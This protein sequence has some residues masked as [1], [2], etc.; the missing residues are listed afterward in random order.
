MREPW[1]A[2]LTPVRPLATIAHNEYA[3]LAFGCFNRA[4]RLSRWDGVAFCIEEEVVDESL[5]VFFHRGPGRRT[6]LVV[7]Y[8]DW[9]WRHL[10]QA[11][12][13]YPQGLS[14]LL[15][16]TQIPIVAVSVDTHRHIEFDLVICI[17]WLALAYVPRH[18]RTSQHYTREGVVE[19]V[20][21]TNDTNVFCT[22]YPNTVVCEE[23]FCF[24]DAVAEL[25]GPLVDIVEKAKRQ[26]LVD[27]AWTNIGRVEAG[28]RN[29]L[30]EFLRS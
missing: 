2:N 21:S 4:I 28:S 23:F 16:T 12:V 20:G 7:L 30:I 29:T 10:V 22:A 9:T 13:D 14:E 25:G 19:C 18:S 17:I 6:D 24:V 8:S 15:H 5:H 26:V 3:H 11:L 27:A 1:R